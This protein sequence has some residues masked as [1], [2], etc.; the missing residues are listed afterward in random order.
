[1]SFTADDFDR[2]K[3]KMLGDFNKAL[4]DAEE[5]RKAEMA[6]F[7]ISSAAARAAVG[8]KSGGAGASPA[9][10]IQEIA[11]AVTGK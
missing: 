5:L 2:A 7:D 4:T 10:A 6:V 3:S 1:M 9:G 8:E 11:I